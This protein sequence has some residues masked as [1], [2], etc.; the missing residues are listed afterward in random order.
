MTRLSFTVDIN[1]KSVRH[2]FERLE[3]GMERTEPLMDAIGTGV[4]GSTHLRF[5]SQSDPEGGSWTALNPGYAAGKRNSRILTE[6]GRLRD[7]INARSSK[8]EARV[9]TNL[10][11]AAIHQFGGTITPKSSSHL[12]FRI[13]GVPVAAKSVTIPARP[14][15]GIS[16][17]DETMI[18]DVVFAFIDRLLPQ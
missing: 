8:N 12:F 11:Y 18:A 16:A 1:D 10:V 14:Y 9:G 15:L 4:A 7:S 13:G 2:G 5:V 17:D 6:S 3:N